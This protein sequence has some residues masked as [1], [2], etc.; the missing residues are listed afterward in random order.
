MTTAANARAV[1]SWGSDCVKMLAQ[2]RVGAR[3]LG[4][5]GRR[6][7][8]RRPAILAPVKTPGSAVGSSTRRNVRPRVASKVRISLT[9]LGVDGGEARQ[10]RHDDREERDERDD[11]ELGQDAEA[12]PEH[13]HGREH[14]DGHRLGGDHQGIDGAADGPREMHRGG[15]HERRGGSRPGSRARP[16]RQCAGS[17]RTTGS[18][19]R[20]AAAA[21]RVRARAAPGSR[22]RR[23][24]RTAPIR[25]A[26]RRAAAARASRDSSRLIR[27][28]PAR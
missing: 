17:W 8:R 7:P 13:E 22:R 26:G 28:P 18:G 19:R 20:R 6:A 24:R 12:E 5:H 2:A 27:A 9:R 3:L 11:H 15:E 21:D 25:R 16:P 23:G 14:R 1:S 4:E 10:R